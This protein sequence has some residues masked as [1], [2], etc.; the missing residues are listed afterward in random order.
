[1]ER[2]EKFREEKEKGFPG[3]LNQD[4]LPE[5]EKIHKI[6]IRENFGFFKELEAKRKCFFILKEFLY[7]AIPH[8]TE[9]QEV[10]FNYTKSEE[11][12]FD[13]TPNSHTAGEDSASGLEPS[14]NLSDINLKEFLEKEEAF[15]QQMSK[16]REKMQENSF[17]E[18]GDKNLVKIPPA[19]FK[20]NKHSEAKREVEEKI[21]QKFAK[22]MQ[23]SV[24]KEEVEEQLE[25]SKD[26]ELKNDSSKID[27]I[28]PDK[29]ALGQMYKMLQNQDYSL[30]EIEEEENVP[31]K[32]QKKE[33]QK[34]PSPQMTRPLHNNPHLT[35]QK[36]VKFSTNIEV[37][38]KPQKTPQP[39]K[40]QNNPRENIDKERDRENKEEEEEKRRRKKELL[41]K[42]MSYKA[43][44]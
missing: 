25:T 18:R 26:F 1:M 9:T 34:E 32:P 44:K 13:V 8:E 22:Q 43:K 30:S 21:Q 4:L 29:E 28:S 6:L 33:P 31:Q 14:M 24:I 41:A 2:N 11:V 35:E 42:R 27:K 12:D 10:D 3:K 38:I 39:Q 40:V 23:N 17:E 19:K 15:L 37:T 20:K 5:L 7:Q 36:R 16:E